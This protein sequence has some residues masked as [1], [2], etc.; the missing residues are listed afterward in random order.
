VEREKA[1]LSGLSPAE[2]LMLSE[3]LAK[4]VVNSP[5]SP[6]MINIEENEE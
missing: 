1:M 3:L 5:V 6:P 4:V 2:T